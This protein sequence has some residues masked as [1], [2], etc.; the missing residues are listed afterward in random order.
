M[1]LKIPALLAIS[2]FLFVGCNSTD[3]RLDL[4]KNGKFDFC[5]QK[6]VKEMVNGYIANPKWEALV[7]SD[8]EDYVNVSGQITYFDKP[9]DMLL[10]FQVDT[11]SERFEVNA[12]EMNGVPQNYFMSDSLLENMCYGD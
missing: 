9:V 3:S 2:S 5:P 12:F 1:K 10:Q 8:G 4:V 7:A 11:D 6:T